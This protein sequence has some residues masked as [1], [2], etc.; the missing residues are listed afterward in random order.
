[1]ISKYTER[2][3]YFVR[4]NVMQFGLELGSIETCLRTA[5]NFVLERQG[6]KENAR[7]TYFDKGRAE[8]VER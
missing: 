8:G 1:M 3:F 5:D 6:M 2:K 7:K 4:I